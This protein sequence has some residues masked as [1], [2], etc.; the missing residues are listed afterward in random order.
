MIE[1]SRPI[2]G[3]DYEARAISMAEMQQVVAC[4]KGDLYAAA[5]LAHF[6]TYSGDERVWATMEKALEA[7]YPVCKAASEAV[8]ALN[9]P[10]DPEGDAAGN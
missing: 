5:M 8:M 1:T 4:D 2:E 9:V 10:S 6:G 7:P 3:T